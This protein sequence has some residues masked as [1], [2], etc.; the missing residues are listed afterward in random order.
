MVL[1]LLDMYLLN[2]WAT[3]KIDFVLASPQ[4]T[5]KFDLYMKLTLGK[6]MAEGNAETQVLLLHKNSIARNKLVE[7]G[8]PT[9]IEA[10]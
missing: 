7:Y 9:S 2:N 6:V 5:I 1:N 4:A 3:R 8:M 10:S